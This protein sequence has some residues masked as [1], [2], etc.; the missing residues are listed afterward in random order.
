[1]KLAKS[2]LKLHFFL[3][4]FNSKLRYFV[5]I[6]LLFNIGMYLL[7]I[8]LIIN[9]PSMIIKAKFIKVLNRYQNQVNF[10]KISRKLDSR[11]L[12]FSLAA[13]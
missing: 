13:F 2:F 12:P 8:L 5:F 7:E 9:V 1:M 10:T 11:V 6:A 3:A 4:S